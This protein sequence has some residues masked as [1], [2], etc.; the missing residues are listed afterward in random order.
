MDKIGVALW[1]IFIV[2]PFKGVHSNT[3]VDSLHKLKQSLKDPN[4]VML[5]W[6]PSLVNPCTWFH[7]DCNNNYAVIRIN[8][9]NSGLSG[10]LVP[11]LGNLKSLQYLYVTIC[12]CCFP[13]L[14]PSQF[15]ERMMDKIGV[16]LWLIFIV[17]PFKGVHSNTEG[18]SLYKVR[19]SLKDPRGAMSSWDPTLVNP[20]TWEHITCVN[21]AVTRM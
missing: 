5:S 12:S 8:L 2:N 3:E 6:D 19:Q 16:V 14:L 15:L 4:G 20:C 18:D 1:L 7:I 11:D 21:N 17:N 10:T 9:G 13:S